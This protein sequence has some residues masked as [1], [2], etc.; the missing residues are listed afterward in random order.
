MSLSAYE[1]GNQ[2]VMSD[3]FI[4]ANEAVPVLT[5]AFL[6]KYAGTDGDANALYRPLDQLR[7]LNPQLIF[8]GAAE[9]ALSDSKDWARRCLE[10]GVAYE[11]HVE[12]GQTHIWAMGSKFI[13]PELRRKTDERIVAWI[14]SHVHGTGEIVH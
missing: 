14:S 13:E 11:L 2:A 1:G 7:G 3:Y 6:G 4:M 5:K 8:V 12:W 9:F 10:A